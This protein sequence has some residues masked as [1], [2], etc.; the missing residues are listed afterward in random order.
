MKY[1]PAVLLRLSACPFR[2]RHM[3]CLAQFVLSEA[4]VSAWTTAAC[5]TTMQ[6]VTMLR[7][8]VYKNNS[9]N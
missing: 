4:A 1:K 9:N 5:T 3:I 6:N 8:I 2:S 7:I